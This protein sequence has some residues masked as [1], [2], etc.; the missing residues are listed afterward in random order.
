MVLRGWFGC[1][2]VVLHVSLREVWTSSLSHLEFNH[3]VDTSP[4]LPTLS[5]SLSFW[6]SYTSI[7][8]PSIPLPLTPILT[9][10]YFPFPCISC[11]ISFAGNV[12]NLAITSRFFSLLI[13][14][15]VLLI[16]ANILK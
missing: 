8:P 14:S 16:S 11:T 1:S 7:I 15:S 2:N 6:Y 10:P 4:P 13:F 12:A 5:L 9:P 3:A